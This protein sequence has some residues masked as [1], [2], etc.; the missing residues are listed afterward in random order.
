M[1]NSSENQKYLQQK[2]YFEWEKLDKI[3]WI[4]EAERVVET[5]NTIKPLEQKLRKEEKN[6]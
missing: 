2:I 4:T 3:N 6:E 5:N 1:K